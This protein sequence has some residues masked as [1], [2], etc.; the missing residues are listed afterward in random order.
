MRKNSPI[1]VAEAILRR[2]TCAVQVGA[3]LSDGFG[4][5]SWGWN[6]SGP[7][8][9]GEHA[10]AMVMRRVNRK[11]LILPGSTLW[12]AARR[13]RNGC[14]VIARPCEA[15]Q[16]LIKGVGQVMWRDGDGIWRTL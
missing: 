8:G 14:P 6:S 12:V 11:R 13:Q 7:S 2:S 10:E 16:R 5:Y 3:C 15:C 1:E 9:M 4:I